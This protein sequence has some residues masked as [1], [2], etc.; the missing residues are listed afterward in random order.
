MLYHSRF[1]AL[2][3]GFGLR[4][5]RIWLFFVSVMTRLLTQSVG[6]SVGAMMF[7]FSNSMSVALSW[8]YL[9]YG[10]FLAGYITGGTLGSSLMSFS[11]SYS[12]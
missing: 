6:L 12:P 7:F 2:F 1:M 10:I 5:I 9:A 8:S 4:Q 11:F 3:S